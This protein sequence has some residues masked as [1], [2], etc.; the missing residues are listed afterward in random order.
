MQIY[1]NFQGFSLNQ[2]VVWVGN[3]TTS[4]QRQLSKRSVEGAEPVRCTKQ[5]GGKMMTCEVSVIKGK[6]RALEMFFV[7]DPCIVTRM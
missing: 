4:V 6:F 5:K 7:K 2:C 3:I 1:G